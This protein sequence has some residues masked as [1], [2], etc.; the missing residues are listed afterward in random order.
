MKLNNVARK[1]NIFDPPIDQRGIEAHNIFREIHGAKELTLDPVL[2]AGASEYANKLVKIG[3]LKHA[4]NAN[5]TGENLAFGCKKG[6]NK[7]LT[8]EEAT[9]Q[10]YE[11]YIFSCI[12]C[13]SLIFYT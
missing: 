7:G 10:W 2:S 12:S 6:S 11:T 13:G 9:K 1:Y 5:G 8:P 3:F 4:R